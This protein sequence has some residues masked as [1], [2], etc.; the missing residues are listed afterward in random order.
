QEKEAARYAHGAI[1]SAVHLS[2]VAISPPAPPRLLQRSESR[3]KPGCPGRPRRGTYTSRMC[4][5]IE[6]DMR[7][8]WTPAARW[9]QGELTSA[10]STTQVDADG[11]VAASFFRAE[12]GD[13]GCGGGAKGGDGDDDECLMRRTLVAHT[14]Y[15]YTQGGNHN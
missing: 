14:D 6:Q 12:A 8:V 2:A 4:V 9:R 5:Y 13:E 3:K 15:I 11:E 10:G 7:D 1:T